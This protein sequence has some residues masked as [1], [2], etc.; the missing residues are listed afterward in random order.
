MSIL[1]GIMFCVGF[2]LKCYWS[3]ESHFESVS[4]IS[5]GVHQVVLKNEVEACAVTPVD[6]TV[7][8]K[9]SWDKKVVTITLCKSL[10]YVDGVYTCEGHKNAP[11][12]LLCMTKK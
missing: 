2:N 8:A 7:F 3:K 4:R 9:T 11:F 1:T 6:S 10:K 5:T 12:Q